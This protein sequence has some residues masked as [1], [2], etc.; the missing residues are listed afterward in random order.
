ML[1]HIADSH[2]ASVPK[3]KIVLG[4]RMGAVKAMAGVRIIIVVF[5][6]GWEEIGNYKSSRVEGEHNGEL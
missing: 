6:N 5:K 3:T 4:A 2:V 1:S